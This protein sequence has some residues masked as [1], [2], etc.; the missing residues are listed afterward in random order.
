MLA[1]LL[2]D[3]PLFACSLLRGIIHLTSVWC[4]PPIVVTVTDTGIP[5]AGLA[6]GTALHQPHL[7]SRQEQQMDPIDFS[8][9]P[10]WDSQIA[11]GQSWISCS[12]A[13]KGNYQS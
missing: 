13:L 3:P 11:G 8:S 7:S 6:A 1:L 12:W 10:S 4:V 2:W 5:S 9:F